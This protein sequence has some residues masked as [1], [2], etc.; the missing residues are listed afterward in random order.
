MTL[1]LL[2]QKVNLINKFQAMSLPRITYN[3]FKALN[4]MA[5]TE[6]RGQ[7]YSQVMKQFKNS[8]LN[9]ENLP[10][11]GYPTSLQY[12]VIRCCDKDMSSF[13]LP[14]NFTA[15]ETYITP[16]E[17]L[18]TEMANQKDHFISFS[19]D[20]FIRTLVHGRLPSHI[21]DKEI[22]QFRISFHQLEVNAVQSLIHLD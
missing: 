9:I 17:P 3:T 14:Y 16:R 13:F 7:W 8:A 12:E 11:S 15:W 10:T 2:F 6:E 21:V 19:K 5:A 20:R 22:G 18:P 1:S 4:K